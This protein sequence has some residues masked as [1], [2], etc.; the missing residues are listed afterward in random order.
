MTTYHWT[1]GAR[2]RAKAQAVGETLQELAAKYDDRLTPRVVV[3]AARPE[4]S[5]LHPCFEWDD[6]RA[7]ELFREGQAR[8]VLRSIRV[9]SEDA[10]TREPQPCFVVV[11]E[12]V[13]AQQH[14]SYMTTA[15]AKEEPL[16]TRQIM[17]RALAELI[18][19]QKR[20]EQYRAIFEIAEVARERAEDLLSS[21]PPE[22]AVA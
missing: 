6:V 16:L 19:F 10:D 20:Y 8:L 22:Q 15:R 3:D 9:V 17:E 13:G 18:T 4:T 2:F 21:I 1:P 14:R 11:T 12:K 7:A 5:P